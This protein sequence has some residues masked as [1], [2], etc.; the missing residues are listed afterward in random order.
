MISIRTLLAGAAA[1]TAAASGSP[2]APAPD[3]YRLVWADEFDRDGK[4]D[5]AK[6]GFEEGFV[7]NGEMQWYQRDNAAVSNGALVIEA[8]RELRPNP[9][10]G[11]PDQKPQFRDRKMIRFTSASLTTKGIRVW[12]YGRFEIRARL[13]AEQGLWPALWF[14]GEKGRWPANGEIDLMEYYQHSVLANFG[15]EGK[16]AG[17]VVWKGAKVPLTELTQDPAW[18]QKFH[19]WRMDWDQD[20]IT[21]WL[22]DRLMNR[23]ELKSVRNGTDPDGTHPFQRPHYLIVNL[24]LGGQNG[25]PLKDTQFPAR[26]EIDYVRVFQK[27]A[28]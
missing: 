13:K 4:P 8:R 27:A 18:D 6:W 1:F 25:G 12:Q 14:V 28:K 3:G 2:G 7:R 11:E 5:P 9:R 10:F 21:L 19:T 16:Q 20:E 15:W 24:A 17:K 26:F 22:D 23:L